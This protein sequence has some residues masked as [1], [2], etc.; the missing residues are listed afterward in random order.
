MK[1]QDNVL[2]FSKVKTKAPFP[3][4][5]HK[6]SPIYTALKGLK[7]GKT[8]AQI[9]NEIGVTQTTVSRWYRLYQ[10]SMLILI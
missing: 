5:L 10:N 8:Q 7:Q 1:I 3:R 4:N 2:V 9:A 6:D